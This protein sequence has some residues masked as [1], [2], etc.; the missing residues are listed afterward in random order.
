MYE[1]QTYE[2]ILK[3]MLDRVSNHIDKREGSLIFNALAPAAAEL[4]Q[5]YMELDIHY[6]LS[7]ADTASG[8]ELTR[9]C[10]EFGVNRKPATKARRK[11]EFFNSSNHPVE[12]SLGSRFSIGQVT[13]VAIQALATGVYIMECEQAGTV[14][15]QQFG[16]MLPIRFHPEL[17]RAELTD[18]LVSGE[19]EETDDMLRKRYYEAV[20]EPAFGGNVSDYK[21]KINGIE[22]VGGSKVFP[23]WNGG[24]TV[25][26]T[27]IASDW[28]EPSSVLVQEVQTLI[29]PVQAQGQGIGIAPI[30]HTVTIAGVS[31]VTMDVETTIICESNT[32]LSQVQP[33][34]EEAIES[35]LLQLRK[36]WAN[37]EQLVVRI[38]FI[39]AAILSVPGVIDVSTTT[40]NGSSTNIL[41]TPEEIP[42]LGTVALQT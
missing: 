42:K 37:E 22:G 17:A 41:L 29:D 14:G 26:C 6:N 31:G 4:A 7:F 40:M 32:T 24:G 9:R 15:N 25:K 19:E 10:A 23:T 33:L 5:M 2:T 13:Y 34:I 3:R 36:N 28:N 21:Q 12:I 1:H 18:I 35:Y 38:A 11:G 30:G 16:T 8:T 39:D 20:N 27:L